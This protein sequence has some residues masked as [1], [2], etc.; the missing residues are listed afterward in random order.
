[1]NRLFDSCFII[2]MLA[3]PSFSAWAQAP[4]VESPLEAGDAVRVTILAEPEGS[5]LHSV[6]ETG[7]VRLPHLGPRQVT[8]IVPSELKRQLNEEYA[9]RFQEPGVEI[10]LMRRVRVLG[11]VKNPGLYHVDPTMTLGDVIA[12]AGGATREGRLEDVRIV[13]NGQ[14][15]RGG[16]EGDAWIAGLRS[17]DQIVV[18]E[19]SWVS[20]NGIVVLGAVIST[21]GFIIAQ[22]AF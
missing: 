16:L 5:G 17:G 12:L 14:E 2:L 13:R 9:L 15:V 1:M 21:A 8:H 6:D 20:R 3:L 19:R 11:E 4:G 22:A 7:V 10:T 18:S